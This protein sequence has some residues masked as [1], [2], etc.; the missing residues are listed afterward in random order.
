MRTPRAFFKPLA[1]GAPQPLAEPPVRLERMLHF[2]PPQVDK[3]RA[4]LPELARQADVLVGNLEDGI[5][6]EA[7][8]SA[9][10][11]LI[12]IGRN[13]D[14]G[15]ATLWAR[16]NALD[17]P[18]VLDDLS[19]LVAAIGERIEVLIVP[20]VD[21]P[22]DIHYLDRLLAQ[23]EAKHR[24]SRPILIHPLMETAQAS[25]NLDEI[26]AASPRL[27]GISLGPSDLAA[28]R[29]M[30]TIGLGGNHPGYGVYGVPAV[31][32]G[33][34]PFHSQDLWHYTLCRL[35]DA[36]RAHGIRP[37]CGAFGDFADPLACEA[38]FRN[39]FV[40]G[41]VGAWSLHPSQLP[42]ARRV[43]SP[44]P[45]EVRFALRIL[46]SMPDGGGV[47]LVDGKM[48]D[49]ATWKQAKVLVDIARLV[50]AREPER[51]ADY[52]L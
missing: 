22:W 13:L 21:G 1:I 4:K 18:W 12:E 25:R 2:F 43:F 38:L 37:F 28:A 19:Q 15:S 50:V 8:E 48:Q 5:P 24:I 7:K 49:D 6:L 46:E 20:K 32:G 44:D 35:V 14:L 9:R 33:E 52:G 34:R 29:A 39:A 23:L 42:I 10:A 47:A 30:K 40:L 27:H 41:C 3:V 51:A 45:A 11:A 17:S 16:I 36:C 31:A 26:A